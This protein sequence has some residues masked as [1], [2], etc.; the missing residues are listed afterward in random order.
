MAPARVALERWLGGTARAHAAPEVVLV[1]DGTRARRAARSP[2]LLRVV[3][4]GGETADER[5]RALMR[6]PYAGR[7]DSTWVVSSDREVQGPARELGF[8]AL[9]AMA[10]YRRWSTRPRGTGTGGDADAGAA[11]R[12][13]PSRTQVEALLAEMLEAR[14]AGEPE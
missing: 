9:G 8:T 7:A 11:P 1:W 3:F 2:A 12:P 5:I 6:G 10:F 13:R 4:T 14:D